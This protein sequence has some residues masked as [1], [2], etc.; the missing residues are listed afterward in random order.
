MNLVTIILAG[1]LGKRMNSDIPKVL[2]KI[3]NKPMIYHVIKVA[4]LTGSQHILI[5][6]GKYKQLI[7][8]TITVW[9]SPAELTKIHYIDQP[10]SIDEN[11]LVRVMGT[12]DA[13]K[14]SLP[15]FIDNNIDEKT[16]VLILSGDVPLIKTDTI[17]R[18]LEK[19]NA[20]LITELVNPF[21]CGRIFFTE[22]DKIQKIVEE[23][24]CNEIERTNKIVNCG[25][26]N[27]N[28]D[29]LLKCIPK[30][31]NNNKNKEYYLTDL[32]EIAIRNNFEIDYY[33]LPI[34]NQREILNINT[35]NE[36]ELANNN[37]IKKE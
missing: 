34:E 22:Q 30:I 6:V 25:I 15:F 35:L 21:G 31:E 26:Y 18:L 8:H 37:K 23:K 19:E 28:V 11:G 4:L 10:E 1:G 17:V 16:K 36:L 12:G 3:D 13:I 14:C 7:E 29:I 5:I 20:L 2:H 9:F 24:D 32:V 33:K 27:M